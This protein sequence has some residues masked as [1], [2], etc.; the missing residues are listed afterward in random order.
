MKI[1]ERQPMRL[2]TVIF[3]LLYSTKKKRIMKEI[4]LNCPI[5][6]K[7]IIF[8]FFLQKKIC[9]HLFFTLT[10][11]N[12]HKCIT[13]LWSRHEAIFLLLLFYFMGFNVFVGMQKMRMKMSEEVEEGKIIIIISLQ[14]LRELK[15]KYHNFNIGNLILNN[16][17]HFHL[18]FLT[19][20][21]NLW[22]YSIFS[23]KRKH[24]KASFTSSFWTPYTIKRASKRKKKRHL[25]SIIITFH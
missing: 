10:D 5:T 24:Q 6:C 2:D 13:F 17:Q 3:L 22:D 15:R 19:S 8:L 23:P 12:I 14:Y 1:I 21:K 7:C 20:L 18:K 9:E 25:N 4:L 16:F 11:Y